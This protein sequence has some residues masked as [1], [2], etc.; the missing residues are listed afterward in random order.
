[1]PLHNPEVFILK[2]IVLIVL[3]GKI[4][5]K[6]GRNNW[7]PGFISTERLEWGVGTWSCLAETAIVL[8]NDKVSSQKPQVV[9]MGEESFSRYKN[10]PDTCGQ[11]SCLPLPS[12]ALRTSVRS[13]GKRGSHPMEELLSQKDQTSNSRSAAH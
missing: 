5:G 11:S 9:A 7:D 2:S 8:D 12:G 4:N 6:L 3:F 13:Q 10:V 1:M